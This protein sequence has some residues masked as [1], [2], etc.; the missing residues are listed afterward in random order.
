[1]PQLILAVSIIAFILGL[2]AVG[3]NGFFYYR[4]ATS[5]YMIAVVG[6]IML[7]L[8]ATTLFFPDQDDST[9]QA[10]Y[11]AFVILS[12]IY[13]LYLSVISRRRRAV[14]GP[15]SAKRSAFLLAI[16]SMPFLIISARFF[17]LGLS[18]HD[19]M[20]SVPW[21]SAISGSARGY[22]YL[23]Y[24]S[25]A[26]LLIVLISLAVR[27]G[28]IRVLIAVAFL[29]ALLIYGG[30]FLAASALMI[31][32]TIRLARRG[33]K[34][35][36]RR[37][38]VWTLIILVALNL[39]AYLR[40][41][42]SEDIEFSPEVLA[43]TVFRQLAGNVY[44]FSISYRSVDPG[45][46]EYLVKKKMMVAMFPLAFKREDNATTFG[47]YLAEMADR[48]FEVGHRVSAVGEAYYLGGW[49]GLVILLLF[50]IGVFSFA[51]LALKRGGE[52]FV[53]GCALVF[54]IFFAFFID[55]AFVFTTVYLVLYI[56]VINRLGMFFV[57]R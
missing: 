39:L 57:R 14:Y 2:T 45:T 20:G 5:F 17:I 56:S 41:S 40:Y 36:L 47:A 9:P 35:R 26:I 13:C 21:R 54:G 37:A 6:F 16:G 49:L 24:D 4:P 38:A 51:D 55:I 11:G 27:F 50:L 22:E 28:K 46:A 31:A 48:P 8:T 42:V 29:A 30:R 43:A 25:G 10:I 32:F 53:L 23:L 34:V 19:S 1:M 3:R 18:S 52:Y 44:D 7:N 33:A 12:S 15:V